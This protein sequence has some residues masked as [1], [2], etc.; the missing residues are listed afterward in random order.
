MGCLTVKHDLKYRNNH[1][2]NKTEKGVPGGREREPAEQLPQGGRGGSPG[3][4]CKFDILWPE[5]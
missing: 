4:A 3:V 5:Q 2:N 1:K